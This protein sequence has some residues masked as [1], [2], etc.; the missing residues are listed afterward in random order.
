[1]PHKLQQNAPGTPDLQLESLIPPK[2]MKNPHVQALFNSFKDALNQLIQGVEIQNSLWRQNQ[3]LQAEIQ[4]LKI[5]YMGLDVPWCIVFFS[6]S[7]SSLII[8]IESLISPSHLE[9]QFRRC[10]APSAMN[11]SQQR[12]QLSCQQR[13]YGPLKTV[14]RTR[15]STSRQGTHRICPWTRQS[16][17][18]MGP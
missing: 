5:G 3:Q 1:M 9:T 14:R 6:L 10:P 15:M 18:Q 13:S 8:L 12:G 2:V 7:V 16:D 17:I 4:S 11:L